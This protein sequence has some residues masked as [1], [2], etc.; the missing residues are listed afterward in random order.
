MTHPVKIEDEGQV[1]HVEDGGLLTSVLPY[2]PF[3]PQQVRFFS[4]FLTTS[5]DSN[6]MGIDGGTTPTE[7][8]IEASTVD[9]Y[10]TTL[11]VL[12]ACGTQPELYEFADSGAALTNGIRVYYIDNQEEVEIANPKSNMSFVRFSGGVPPL[13]SGADA[14]MM[15]NLTASGDYGMIW[16]ISLMA[17]MPPFGIKLD[18]NSRQKLAF[19]IRDDCRDA[20]VFNC[21]AF[22]F[23]RF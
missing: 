21:R 18:T 15:R 16:H 3:L 2:P 7:F 10:I 6:D 14:F 17:Y 20:D 23:E 8:Y 13:G 11:S 19:Y 5:A 22:G 4:Q 12:M 9:R 1:A